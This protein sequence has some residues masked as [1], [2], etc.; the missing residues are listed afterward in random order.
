M[1]LRCVSRY[2]SALGSF[3]PGELLDLKDAEGAY[4]LRDSPGSFEEVIEREDPLEEATE[5][6]AEK[7]AA[8]ST[9]TE[10]GIVAPDRRMRGGKKRGKK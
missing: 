3:K 8:M 7:L 2:S 4:L 5:Q 10:T 9:E 6:V 1:R